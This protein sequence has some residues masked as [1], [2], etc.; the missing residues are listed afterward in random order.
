M[1]D[2]QDNPVSRSQVAQ[3]LQQQQY[4]AAERL[5]LEVIAQ[6]PN[7]SWPHLLLGS[8]YGGQNR[9][10]E[11]IQSYA[12]AIR[13]D[14][15]S[16][17]AYVGLAGALSD[18]GRFEE[19]EQ[20]IARAKSLNP[21]D[22]DVY[23][24]EVR[25]RLLQKQVGQAQ[26]AALDGYRSIRSL[27]SAFLLIHVLRCRYSGLLAL[28]MLIVGLASLVFRQSS[29]GLAL[30]VVFLVMGATQAVIGYYFARQIRPVLQTVLLM[31]LA[32]VMFFVVRSSYP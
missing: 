3:L 11:A 18:A 23:W 31:V 26:Q 10:N 2:G 22:G 27:R 32:T 4:A 29:V 16:N 1:R 13:L 28:M 20:T 7:L 24:N 19:A 12:E 8:A 25:M 5:A 14:P 17:K 21:K 30:L 6:N 15:T 9:F